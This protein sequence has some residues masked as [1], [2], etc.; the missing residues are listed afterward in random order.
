MTKQ[1]IMHPSTIQHRVVHKNNNRTSCSS[2]CHPCR[3]ATCDLRPATLVGRESLHGEPQTYQTRGHVGTVHHV[4]SSA[5]HQCLRV[6]SG[7]DSTVLESRPARMAHKPICRR[8]HLFRLHDGKETII[9]PV[10]SFSFLM[11]PRRLDLA[12]HSP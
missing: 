8:S 7:R 4:T 10:F 3:A 2:A 9:A 1:P 6:Y 11:V 5:R 12:S